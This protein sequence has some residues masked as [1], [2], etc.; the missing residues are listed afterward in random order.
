M[1]R[2]GFTAPQEGLAASLLAWRLALTTIWYA[3]VMTSFEE[4]WKLAQQGKAPEA[5]ALLRTAVTHT[6]D[7]TLARTEALYALAN[8][9]VACGDLARATAP[10]RTAVAMK[11]TSQDHEKARLTGSMNLGE[12]LVR[13]G[14]LEEA[15]T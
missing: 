10:L 11:S 8:L 15:D 12:I 13:I 6:Q 1:P 2:Y 3:P 4:A 5:E 14:E 7:G 9:L